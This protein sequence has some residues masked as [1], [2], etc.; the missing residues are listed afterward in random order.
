MFNV[1]PR[2]RFF[3]AMR[4]ERTDR[5]P[6]CGITDST[7]SELMQNLQIDWN[8]ASTDPWKMAKLALNAYRQLGLESIRIPFCHTYESEIL[9]CKVYLGN[10][11][12]PP[13]I[14][15]SPYLN[16]PDA[17]LILMNQD[18]VM[19]QGRNSVIDA[20]VKLLYQEVWVDL[21]RILG[22][23]GPFTIAGNL[24]GPENLLMWSYNEPSVARRFINYAT[25]YQK[26]WMDEVGCMNIDCVEMNDPL[27]SND[28]LTRDQISTMVI[29]NLSYV[30]S[31]LR[32][33]MKVVHINGDVS[34]ILNGIIS[35]GATGICLDDMTDPRIASEICQDRVALIGNIGSGRYYAQKDETII[36]NTKKYID[37]G[38]NIISPGPEIMTGRNK[39][40]ITNM[41]HT[42]VTTKRMP[43]HPHLV[44]GNNRF[45]KT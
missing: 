3:Q 32:E 2:N 34:H 31:P 9:G 41:V 8:G 12:V 16:D 42:C 19:K 43:N 7:T 10:D 44:R 39:S 27:A 15:D 21:P 13:M 45:I 5:P 29:P 26:M 35:T 24:A 38:Y 22:S 23:T 40:V 14:V 30:F 17:R 33:T 28:I 6:I 20:A 11:K 4:C 18:D 1:T 25:E 37:A 36:D